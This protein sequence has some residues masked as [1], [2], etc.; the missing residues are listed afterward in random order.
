[1]ILSASRRTD[2]PCCY[3]DWMMNRIRAGY[4]LTRNPMNPS[5]LSRVSLSPDIVDCIVFWTKDARNMMPYLWELEQ[6]GYRYYFQFTLTPY[7]RDLE[8]GLREKAEIARTFMELSCLLGRERVI[9]RYDPIVLNDR[10]TVTFH[11]A[12]FHSLCRQ[13]APYTDTVTISF[14]DVYKKLRHAGI[15]PA[16]LQETQDLAGYIGLASQQEGITAVACCEAADLRPYGIRHASC[17]DRERIE[18]LC[19][20][21][22]HILRDKNQRA[23]CGCCE[24]VDIGAYDTCLNG[25]VYCYANHGREA[26]MRRFAKHDPESAILTGCANEEDARERKGR[27]NLVDV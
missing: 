11:Q 20:Q 6:R 14:V 17:I 7:G 10:Y 3:P 18:R 16:S 19:G 27:S 26:V 21:P 25:C 12:Q 9:W 13:L 2:L 1:M 15:R 22:L 5:Q 23:G 24:S 8:P 4:A